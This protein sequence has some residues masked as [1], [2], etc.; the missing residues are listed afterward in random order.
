M[1]RPPTKAAYLKRTPIR[2]A[3]RHATSQDRVRISGLMMSLKLSGMPSG[4]DTELCGILGDEVD[5]AAW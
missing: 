4:L 2:C 1:A 3:V 5:Q